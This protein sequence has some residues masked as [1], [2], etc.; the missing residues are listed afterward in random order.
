EHQD[1]QKII[2]LVI[3]GVVPDNVLWAVQALVKFIFQAQGLLI[4]DDH[5]HS[6]EQALLKFHHYKSSVI[7]AGGQQGENGIIPHSQIPK[8]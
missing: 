5:L 1:I 7:L 2:V 4:F 3:A 6:I 8:L